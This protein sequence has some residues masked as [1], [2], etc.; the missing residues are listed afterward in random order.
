M[1]A[2]LSRR[3]SICLALSLVSPTPTVLRAA[4][5]RLGEIATAIK[6]LVL[7]MIK[8]GD[9]ETREKRKISAAL[10]SERMIRIAAMKRIF[11]GYL[12]GKPATTNEFSPHDQMLVNR[13]LRRIGREIANLAVDLREIDPGWAAKNPKLYS[14]L[15]A[16][17][18]GKGL[19]WA[20]RFGRYGANQDV[21]RL[22]DWMNAEAK[23]LEIAAAAIQSGLTS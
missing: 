4:E 7:F 1:I 15:I 5:L 9:L 10:I 14:E 16:I 13:E 22:R 18:H 19:W 2:T 3:T 23:E 8:R 6:D 11:A 12:Q 21:G 17:G 20:G